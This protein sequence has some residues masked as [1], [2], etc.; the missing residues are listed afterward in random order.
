M[1]FTFESWA[2]GT[3]REDSDIDIG[4]YLKDEKKKTRSG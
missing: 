3:S 4:V 2:K 1:A